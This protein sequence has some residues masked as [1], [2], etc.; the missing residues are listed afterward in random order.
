VELQTLY[1]SF[2]KLERACDS[3]AQEGQSFDRSTLHSSKSTFRNLYKMSKLLG[4]Y[5]ELTAE[6]LLKTV[7][8]IFE[9][10]DLHGTFFTPNVSS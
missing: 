8:Q 3:R 9:V 7:G 10:Y 5:L 4:D 6:L 1:D 2:D